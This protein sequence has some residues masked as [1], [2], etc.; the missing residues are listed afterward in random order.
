MY[1]LSEFILFYLL[2]TM[3]VRMVVTRWA[4]PLLVLTCSSNV[5][6][7]VVF[8]STGSAMEIM[9]VVTSPMKPMPTVLNQVC[10]LSGEVCIFQKLQYLGKD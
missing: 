7:V 4:A 5:P 10:A 6:M 1:V 8:L 2:Q 3:T 9:T